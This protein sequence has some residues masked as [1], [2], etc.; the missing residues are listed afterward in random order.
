MSDESVRSRASR[1]GRRS[2]AGRCRYIARSVG[3]KLNIAR[4]FGDPKGLVG[5]VVGKGMAKGNAGFNGWVVDTL[6][7]DIEPRRILEFGFGPGIA[8]ASLLKAFPTAE[9]FGVDRSA[10]MVT[11]ATSRNRAAIAAGRLRLIRGDAG[12]VSAFAPLDLIMAVHVVYFWA[13]P[14]APL[15]QLRAALAPSGVLALGLLLK[16]DMPA[17]ARE[18]FP[19]IG[20]HVY[21]T[22]DELRDV[23]L[24][25]GFT[26]VEFRTKPDAPALSGRLALAT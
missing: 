9:V 8:I 1:R 19:Q 5:R 25:A 17:R 21:A 18:N 4:Q 2:S 24:A 20:G 26:S 11:E 10:A 14:V 3:L 6:R 12:A 13:D 7:A 22:E 16:D 15:K 23:V